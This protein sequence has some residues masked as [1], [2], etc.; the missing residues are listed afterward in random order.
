MSTA[1]P[2]MRAV[3]AAQVE[4]ALD[5]PSLVEKLRLAFQGDTVAPLRHHHAFPGKGSNSG[6]GGEGGI[7]LLK[8]VW[9]S[10]GPVAVKVVNIV[11]D[12]A[13]RGLPSVLGAVLMFD[14]ETG[15]PLAVIDGQSLT[16]R[17]TAAASAL[18]AD[19]LARRGA[20]RLLVVGTGQLAPALAQAHATIRPIRE[21]DVWGRSA[22]KAENT[23]AALARAGMTARAVQD[24]RAAAGEADIVTCA[25]LSKEPL[26]LGAWLKPGAHLDLVGGFTPAM[27]EC[28]DEAV[29]RA[30][31]YVDTREGALA[32]AGDLITP[33]R[34]G[35]IGEDDVIGDLADLCRGRVGGRSSD[36][37]ITLFK[38]VGTALEDLAAAELV[39]E[40]AGAD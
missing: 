28:D 7:M 27:R 22:E 8:P 29:R 38:S 14:G 31:V 23:A 36:D 6:G 4:R 5:Y 11:P 35:A 30:R 33:I 13:Q 1:L 39:L 10:G 17:R 3:T 2:E 25:T 15:A 21:V 18:A 37:E 26:V 20:S 32:E 24:L 12:N 34:T 19:Y 16:V 9:R 40:R